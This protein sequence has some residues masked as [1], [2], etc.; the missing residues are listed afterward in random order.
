MKL[1][2]IDDRLLVQ[3][4]EE[5]E[6]KSAG[7]IIIPDTAK[8]KPRIGTIQAVGT[9]EEV[10]KIFKVGDKIVYSKYSGDEIEIEGKKLLIVKRDDVLAVVK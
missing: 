10:Q 3:Q 9:D 5:A 6:S 4:Q 8:E 1:Q 2:P 7:G